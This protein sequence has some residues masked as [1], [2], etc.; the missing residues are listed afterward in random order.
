MFYYFALCLLSL[1]TCVVGDVSISNPTKG[2]TF[3]VSGS[4]VSVTVTWIES[5]ADPLLTDMNKYTFL[6]CTGPNS[7]INC[8]KSTST[9][10]KASELSSYSKTMSI[11]ASLGA[12]GQYYIQIYATTDNGYTIHYTYRFTLTGMTGSTEPSGDDTNPPTAQTSLAADGATAVT[13]TALSASFSLPYSEQ[14]G[15]TRYAPMQTQ[16]GTTVTAT[17]WSRRFPTSS[18]TY[19]STLTG[20][21]MLQQ[22]ST[23]TP[24]WSYTIS[25]AANWASP[26][27]YPSD[28]GGWYNPSSRIRSASRTSLSS[29]ATSSA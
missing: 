27:P 15:P 28:N 3:A 7:D 13:G 19:F 16:P 29:S 18:V 23:V 4:S 26:A 25:S 8:F 12:D 17:T 24:G 10:V 14:T 2:Q 1:F 22:V 11:P 9:T 6:V 21:T 20:G 5:N